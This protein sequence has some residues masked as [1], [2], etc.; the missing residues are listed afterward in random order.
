MKK[1]SMLISML[2][3]LAL[4]SLCLCSCGTR[5]TDDGRPYI[6]VGDEILSRE[7]IGYFFYLAQR[8]MIQEAGMVLGEGGNATQENVDEFWATTEIEGKSALSVARSAAADNA[9]IQT[10]QYLKAVDEG[11]ELSEAESEEISAQINAAIESSGGKEKFNEQLESMNS[12]VEAYKQILTENKYLQKLYDK[13]DSEGLIEVTA[14]EF[15]VYSAENAERIPQEHLLEA[16]KKD[17]FNKLVQ[18]WGTEYTIEISDEKMKE[19]DVK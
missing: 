16:A 18:Q 11:I 9:V 2:L 17:K 14:E 1:F 4:L 3:M 10:I 12:S 6:K 13:Y 19:F 8:N 15:E 7:Y 5:N